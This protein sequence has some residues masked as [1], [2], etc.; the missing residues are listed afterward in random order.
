MGKNARCHWK[1]G[2]PAMAGEM[3]QLFLGCTADRIAVG[4]NHSER[5]PYVVR[6]HGQPS[7]FEDFFSSAHLTR[8][9]PQASSGPFTDGRI[10]TAKLQVYRHGLPKNPSISRLAPHI[11][12]SYRLRLHPFRSLLSSPSI[13]PSRTCHR[14]RWSGHGACVAS[15]V[16]SRRV[17]MAGSNVSL[18]T[19]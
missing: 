2:S 13:L 5:G 8:N 4:Q 9:E 1:P 14:C 6:K 10:W 3:F 18:G 17:A 11:V 7:C 16:A 12:S 15:R 19:A